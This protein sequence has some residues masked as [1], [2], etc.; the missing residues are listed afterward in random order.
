M[1]GPGPLGGNDPFEGMPIFRDLA[2][3]F[4]GAGPVNWE[5][6]RQVAVW[7]A[8]EGASESN[9]EP[10]QRIRLEELA[11]VAELHISEATG[12]PT[13]TAGRVPTVVPVTKTEWANRTL[14]AYRPLLEKLGAGL[15]AAGGPNVAD[16]TTELL[17]NIT[18]L[19]SPVL[20]GLQSGSMVGYLAQKALGQ[21]HLPV[22]RPP[23]DELIVVASTVDAFARDWSL[24]IDDVRLWVCLNELTHHAVISRPHVRHRLDTLLLEYA[25]GFRADPGALESRL[26]DVDMAN[27]ASLQEALGDPE[28]ILGAIQTDEQRRVIQQLG[29]VVAA[30]EGYVDVVMDDVGRKL[31]GSYGP[32]TEAL[33]RRRVERTDADTFV[34][35]LLGLE[36]TQAQFDRGAAF[37]Q[38]VVERAGTDG[39]ARLWSDDASLPTPAEVDAPGLWLARIGFYD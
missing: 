35:R 27:P 2:R 3:M 14:D 6:A 39:L 34:E 37:A 36:M 30:V 25:G 11:R 8:T 4:S 7:T 31:I 33:R 22:P 23:A 21:Y 15:N 32:L 29:A 18:Q 5:I 9:V 24:P 1:S 10:L 26:G 13:S 16:P 19:M 28:T 20:V 38:G 17:G 12:L